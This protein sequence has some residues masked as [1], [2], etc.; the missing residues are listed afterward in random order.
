MG[1]GTV[2]ALYAVLIYENQFGT[3]CNNTSTDGLCVFWLCWLLLTGT[4]S[5]HTALS[6]EIMD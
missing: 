1:M 3:S 5:L 6:A 2:L 4:G